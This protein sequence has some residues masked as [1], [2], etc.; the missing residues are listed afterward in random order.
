MSKIKSALLASLLFFSTALPGATYANVEGTVEAENPTV[1]IPQTTTNQTTSSVENTV[2]QQDTVTAEKDAT[3]SS[4]EV[5]PEQLNSPT[6]AQPEATTPEKPAITEEQDASESTEQSTADTEQ[7]NTTEQPAKAQQAGSHLTVK[8]KLA[9]VP[10]SFWAKNEVMQL[11]EMGVIGGYPDAEFRPNLNINRGQAANLFKG[12]LKLP[13]AK[14]QNK[15]SDVS[16]KSSFLQGVFSTYNA[17]IFGGKPDGRFGVSDALTRE[18]MATTLVRAFDLKDTGA[19]L[20]FK[21]WNKISESHR[22]NVKILAQHGITTG[23]E[24]GTYD[25]KATVNRVTFSV[26]LHRAL[27]ATNKITKNEYT[28]QAADVS[29]TFKINRT[30]MN[31]VQVTSDTNPLYLR[32]TAPIAFKGTTTETYGVAKDTIYNYAVGN[33]GATVK[34]TIRAL[35]NGD[36]FVFTTLTNK[37]SSK[38]TVDLFHKASNV[39]NYRLYRY[40]RFPISKN[41]NDVFGY[42]SS[43]YPTG[44]MR[45]MSNEKLA[46][47]RMVGQAYRSKQLTQSYKDTGGT[48]Y[49]RDLQSEY[50]AYSYALLGEELFSFYTLTSNGNDIVD[51]WYMDSNE[52][53]FKTDENM[54][55]WMLETALNYKKRN[56]WYT[57][58]GPFNKMATTTEPMPKSYQGFGRNL[59]LVKEDR[60]LVLFKEQGDRYFANV[61]KNSFI[62]LDKF[63]GDAPY[64]K[65]EVTSTYLKNLYDI[66]APFIDTRFNEQIALFYYNSGA[67]FNIPNYKEPLR[68]YAD[69]LASR[70]AAGHVININSNAYY[71]SDYF[72]VNQQVT[73]H[74]SMNHL[75]GGMNILLLAYQEFQDTKYL[76]AATAVSRALQIEKNK[77]IRANGDIWY[78]VNAKGEFAGDDYQHLTLEDLINSYKY[79]KDVDPSQLPLYEEMIIS[80]AN[81]LSVNQYGYTMKIKN[82]LEE[83]GMSD[84][85]PAGQLYTDAL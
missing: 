40:D 42:D 56:S 47:D 23:R 12:A 19:T 81:Y 30:E 60:A 79:W 74:A 59:L 45:I 72:P 73:T 20:T 85:L 6:L 77:W 8:Q 9:D 37:G 58:E 43:S 39:T 50:E 7:N 55:G 48:S 5:Q 11:V 80:K 13:D 65:T 71:I 82:G 15:F 67:E 21:D 33:Q 63:K 76:E 49:M 57:A 16:N 36:D 29:K 2:E 31:F 83:I 84:Y 54:N 41:A 22:E 52:R 27:V 66:T 32:S 51:T 61:V 18:Q 28:V 46:T 44:L 14:Y 70:K 34:V 35:E 24:D 38:L 4:T 68:N 62:S 3:S 17:G 69:L 64:W 25:P 75:L 78:R 26:M 53:L 10:N 1:Q